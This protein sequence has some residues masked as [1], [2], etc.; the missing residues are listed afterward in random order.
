M[1]FLIS[2]HARGGPSVLCYKN[3]SLYSTVSPLCL[4]R[5]T[6]FWRDLKQG[7]LSGGVGLP[8]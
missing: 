4:L 1:Y 6:S 8:G 2:K 7:P 5:L 3:C